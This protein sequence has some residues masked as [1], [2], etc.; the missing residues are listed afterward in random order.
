M[1]I[2]LT[3]FV[4]SAMASHAAIVWQA[5]APGRAW[6][7]DGVGGGPDVDWIQE[8]AV[9]DLPGAPD[10]GLEPRTS[11]DDYYFA[12][13][14][15]TAVDGG[16]YTPVGVVAADEL[17]AERAFA[18]VDNS[19][20]FHFN[21][22]TVDPADLFSVSF[23]AYNLHGQG[24]TEHYGVEVY[25]NN[26]LVAAE[27]DVNPGNINTVITTPQFTLDSVNAQLGPGFDNYVE[28]RGIN[29]NASGGGN[30][31]GHNYVAL[32]AVSSIPPPT[33]DTFTANPVLVTP[34]QASSLSW[35]AG[36]F[37]TLTLNPGDIDVTTLTTIDVT[38]DQT[39]TYTLSAQLDE[40][41]V[42]GEVT[43][44]VIE[45]VAGIMRRGCLES[46][47]VW[48]AGAPGR[49]WPLDGIGGG[50]DVDFIQESGVNNLPGSPTSRLVAQQNDD[51]YYFAG[52]Y[53]TLV[54]GGAYTPV[55][56]V[57]TDELGA[58]RAFAGTDNSLRYHFNLPADGVGET[59]L[60]SVSFE[61]YNLE[62]SVGA[63]AHYGVEVYF[64]N[65][66]VGEEV[67]INPDNLNTVITT[68]EFTLD[69][70]NAQLGPG[71]DNYVELRGVNYN[72]SGGGNWMGSDYAAL[73]VVS[74]TAIADSRLDFSGV[75]GQDDWHYG[76][77]NLTADGGAQDYEA[78]ADFIAFDA[79][80]WTG[81]QWELPGNPPWTEL[82]REG[83]HP[84]GSNNAENGGGLH[85]TVRRW[86]AG[87]AVGLRKPVA[88]CWNVRK[89]NLNGGS[90]VTGAL[91]ING[92]RVDSLQISGADDAGEVRTFYA[93]IYA[94]DIV[95][96]I[97]S[98][99]GDNGDGADGFDGSANW[100]NVDSYIPPNP[101]QPDGTVF[102][103]AASLEFRLGMSIASNGANLDFKWDSQAGK[104]YNLR[105]V[106][107]PSAPIP[108]GTEPPAP[109]EW[110]ILGAHTAI[111]ATP[112]ENTL[113]IP[114][115]VDPSRYFVIE[116]Y[117]APPVVAFSDDLE[118][119]VG[120]WTTL[121]NDEVGDTV[122]QL[123]TPAGSTGPLTG[124]DD[125]GNAWCTNMGDYGPDA[126]ISLR[127][128]AIDLSGV[129]SAT[130]TFE[131]Y[132]DADGFGD[133]AKIRFLRAS[134]QVQ[135]GTDTEIDMTPIDEDWIT[136]S[137]PIDP[138]AIGETVLIE[139]N[140]T[141]DSGVDAF[142]GLSIDNIE[143]GD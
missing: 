110:P 53:T 65:V 104:L 106:T 41:V 54:D 4:L 49:A 126:D 71:F 125:S 16:T 94:G 68:P 31:M 18:D 87:D 123:G 99:E 132:R 46:L 33:I 60:L 103:P 75:Q 114:R 139:W 23:E 140:F 138:E 47:T 12:G 52:V 118:S 58:E 128:P 10:S 30:W 133:A 9:N 102:V 113:T 40:V 105:S 55:G 39:T 137:V 63:A 17:G 93:N 116:E 72:D 43:V 134:D 92:V 100:L 84:N 37:D 62:A 66:L 59:D 122:W 51:D 135:L 3:I 97:L 13:V 130:L 74:A 82:G 108:P 70:V 143:V 107:D 127:S 136:L 2:G 48:Q 76:Y 38:P 19:S 88:L 67:D 1:K 29:Y 101:V 57:A 6:P 142:S 73:N 120:D 64:N 7:Q 14:Y 95:D 109:S 21:L 83:S 85:W 8:T 79:G 98:S 69:S 44:A 131:A 112:P 121:V 34:G 78:V 129:A 42:T 119:G 77:R 22:T 141:S 124:A 96:L 81:S 11:D 45:D 117:D 24:G 27:V 61:A 56:V 36:N 50:P 20:R 86:I 91:H 15:T 32:N 35:T 26:V 80:Q 28:L 89:T 25:F 90:G 115:P 5:G 111:A